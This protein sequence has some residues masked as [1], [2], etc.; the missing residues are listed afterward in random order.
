MS[1]VGRAIGLARSIVI[2]HAIP[3]RHRR[4]RRLYGA[5]VGPG[6]LVFDIGAHAGNRTRG[7]AA[8]GCRVIA[9][10][11]NPDF[12]WLIRRLFTR[13]PQVQV[14]EAAVGRNRA[15]ATL[16]ISDRTPT[17]TT[18]AEGWRSAR[19]A[20]PGF[21]GVQWNRNVEVDVTTIDALI[22][23]C[24]TP[25]FVKLDIEGAESEAL[26]GLTRPVPALSFEY[27]PRALGEVEKC[28][29]RLAAI[30]P[31][32]YNWSLGESYRLAER[33]WL[34]GSGLLDRLRSPLA[35]QSSGDVYA[36]I[37]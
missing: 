12:A 25:V 19:A 7:F 27:L 1:R 11:P 4:M 32:R 31:Y 15:R 36:K 34:D 24:G 21:A 28:V 22:D 29:Q 5:F 30:G 20:E 18:L 14:L 33:S 35:Q 8:L 23:R 16:R 6:D 2:Y 13:S 26:A 37:G 17:V 10:E 3:L 9:L